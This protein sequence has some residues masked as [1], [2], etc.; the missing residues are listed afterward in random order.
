M[1]QRALGLFELLASETERIVH[2]GGGGYIHPETKEDPW[3]F[4]PEE[5]RTE[6]S[7][8]RRGGPL[9]LPPSRG[10]GG[11]VRCFGFGNGQIA[12]IGEHETSFLSHSL[13]LH[14]VMV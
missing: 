13:Q 5:A 11:F 12:Q 3:F 8:G 4:Q 9:F 10:F 7:L 14:Y 6:A 2:T 1:P